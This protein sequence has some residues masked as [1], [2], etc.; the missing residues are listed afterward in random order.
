MR[1]YLDNTTLDNLLEGFQLIDHNW[2]YVYVNEAAAKHGQSKKDILFDKTM[3]ELYPGIEQTGMFKTLEK[4]MKERTSS[5]IENEFT[6]PNGEKAWFEL[7]IEPVSEGLFI[8]S[9]DITARKKAEQ[10][11]R[12][13][14]ESLE[15]L[16]EERTAELNVRNKDLMDSIVYAKRIQDAQLPPMEEILAAFPDCFVLHKPKDIVSGDFYFFHQNEKAAYIAS[17][18]CTGHGVPGALMSVLG[19]EKLDDAL[20]KVSDTGSILQHLNKSVKFSLRQ[21]NSE[22]PTRDG[23]EVALCS[24]NREQQLLQFSGANR[25][26][27]II[28][29]NAG[30]LEEVEPT[31]HGIGGFTDEEQT[32]ERREI[33][34]KPGD[35]FYIF[36]DGYAHTFSGLEGKKLKSK[37]F[38][39]LLLEIRHEPMVQQG[40]LLEEFIDNYKKETGQVDDILVIGFRL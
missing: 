40:R 8:L 5:K 15:K 13:M 14:N 27:W 38:K 31:K 18:D 17:V 7:R 37:K 24:V 9:V 6:Y 29:H 33:P 3:M 20:T 22:D 30:I 21:S 26:L 16:V 32:F 39:E 10:E 36:S 1:T 25:P 28:R 11:L 4:C 12:N 35:C 34:Y 19:A 2:R 23:M